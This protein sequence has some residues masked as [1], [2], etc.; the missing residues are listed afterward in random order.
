MTKVFKFYA[1]V[2]ATIIWI[3]LWALTLFVGKH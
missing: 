1:A 2:A 3:L